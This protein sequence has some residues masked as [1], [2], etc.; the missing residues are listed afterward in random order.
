MAENPHH[1][2]LLKLLS[3]FEIQYL[4]VAGSQGNAVKQYQA[5]IARYDDK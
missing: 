2:E 5:R 4:T 3:E 1:K